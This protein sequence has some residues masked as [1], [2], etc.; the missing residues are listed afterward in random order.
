MCFQV[1]E[2]HS[3]PQPLHCWFFSAQ[4]VLPQVDVSL[5]HSSFYS[6]VPSITRPPSSLVQTKQPFPSLPVSITSPCSTFSIV[7]NSSPKFV[8]VLH[9]STLFCQLLPLEPIISV[10]HIFVFQERICCVFTGTNHTLNI[11][12]C[13]KVFSRIIM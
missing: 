5:S 12:V 3:V 8:V 2:V 7:V 4:N 11:F 1:T 13:P 6:N 9:F 10:R